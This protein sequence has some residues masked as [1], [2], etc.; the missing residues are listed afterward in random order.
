MH[1]DH[2]AVAGEPGID[3]DLIDAEGDRTLNG[4][5]CILRL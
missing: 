2:P 4:A 1:E 5:E 3:F